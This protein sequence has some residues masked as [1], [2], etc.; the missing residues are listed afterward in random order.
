MLSAGVRG[1]DY[2]SP[3]V[4][5]VRRWAIEPQARAARRVMAPCA[6]PLTLSL[7]ISTSR[8]LPRDAGEVT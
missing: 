5:K 6:G 2:L 7:D 4:G 3:Y 8:P 1:T